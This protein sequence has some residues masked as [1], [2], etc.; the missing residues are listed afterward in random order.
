MDHPRADIKCSRTNHLYPKLF[1][2][3]ASLAALVCMCQ[4]YRSVHRDVPNVF[5]CVGMGARACDWHI[6]NVPTKTCPH[7]R[8]KMAAVTISL[9]TIP[10]S[11]ATLLVVNEWIW[12]WWYQPFAHSKTVTRRPNEENSFGTWMTKI[13]PHRTKSLSKMW[14][15][16]QKT[17]IGVESR[18]LSIT[19]Y[20]L[21]FHHC[22]LARNTVLDTPKFMHNNDQLFGTWY[23]VLNWMTHNSG[24]N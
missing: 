13:E 19:G 15:I 14:P 18:C 12:V 21:L 6:P 4:M 1:M 7:T 2:K 16:P 8:D 20:N 5:V 11:L 10:D 24:T 3:L 23:L 22:T 9:V 17:I